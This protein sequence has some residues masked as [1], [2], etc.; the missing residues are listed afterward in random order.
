MQ[1]NALAVMVACAFSLIIL[2]WA[3]RYV[4]GVS[5]MEL[6]DP[7]DLVICDL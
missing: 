1:K 7:V 2:A 6:P 5:M 3:N 4:F